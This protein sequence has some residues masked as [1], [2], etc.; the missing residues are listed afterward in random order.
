MRRV[1]LWTCCLT[2]T[3]AHAGEVGVIG[4]YDGERSLDAQIALSGAIAQAI[5]AVPDTHAVRLDQPGSPLAGREDQVLEAALLGEARRQVAD[6]RAL[7]T[8]GDSRGAARLV[9]QAIAGF[10]AAAP[11][12]VSARDLWDARLL[13]ASV[14]LAHG[15]DVGARDAVMDALAVRADRR[16]EAASW[17][18]GVIRLWEEEHQ[19]A[20]SDT[21]TIVVQATGA[22]G[23]VPQVWIDGRGVGEAPAR[24]R[25]VAV[26]SHVVTV[27]TA[28]GLGGFLPVD[29]LAGADRTVLVPLGPLSL[30]VAGTTEQGR[31]DQ[32]AALVRAV[33]EGAEVDALLV[34]GRDGDAF[35]VQL[36]T[37][38]TGVFTEP[39]RLAATATAAQIGAAVTSLVGAPPGGA[40]GASAAPL[41]VGTNLTLARTLLAP[42]GALAPS[43]ADTPAS[44]VAPDPAPRRARWPVWVGVGVGSAALVAGATVLG[45]LL[46]G[47]S[48]PGEGRT[49]GTI[50][51]L[52]PN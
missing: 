41:D 37:P 18:S 3:L 52:P 38:A 24:V 47:A 13:L 33:G 42:H 34:A 17:P 15:D 11:Y 39:V 20:V 19:T 40:P 6:G 27:R 10:V 8:Q 1:V 43:L 14:R 31:A 35:V 26:G 21:S 51:V 2:T 45:V 46:G 50:V 9:E 22:L 16:P 4:V 25:D 7:W 36:F 29:A 23:A 32:I 30:G 49:S 28:D 44:P 48:G 5:D 12:V